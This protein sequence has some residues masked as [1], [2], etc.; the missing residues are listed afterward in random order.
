MSPPT[1]VFSR[2]AVRQER[3]VC[4]S[5]CTTVFKPDTGECTLL[6]RSHESLDKCKT[7][8]L[9]MTEPQP[10][11]ECCIVM[12]PMAEFTMGMGSVIKERPLLTKATMP[13]GHGFSAVA[14]LYHFA[15][16]EMTCPC[17]RG[18]HSKVRMSRLSIPLH[19]RAGMVAQMKRSLEE[20]R[21]E[22]ISS[23]A[24]A[25]VSLLEREVNDNTERNSSVFSHLTRR[26]LILRVYASMDSSRPVMV[27]EIPFMSSRTSGGL[28]QL[29][30]SGHD[31][32]EVNRNLRLLSIAVQGYELV[33][34]TW[35]THDGLSCVIRSLR[36]ELCTGGTVIACVGGEGGS[37]QALHEV[38][39]TAHTV[40]RDGVLEFEHFVLTM[41]TH[42]LAS[43][44]LA[45]AMSRWREE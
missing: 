39:T 4:M 1:T 37:T 5:G 26:V 14:L 15:R 6:V 45:N 29:S 10:E 9:D 28:L 8:L 19:I 17:C 23:D 11:E 25:V 40:V 2:R 12:E 3:A 38:S 20:E 31:M 24:A 13:C 32:R 27:Q 22:Q 44:V 30:S 34:G 36:F 33:V 18:G 7:M 42:M 43:L 16:N 35:S 41:P 21:E